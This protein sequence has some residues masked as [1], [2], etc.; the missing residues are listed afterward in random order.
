MASRIMFLLLASLIA[1]HVNS[2]P[3]PPPP[4][5]NQCQC[6][7]IIVSSNGATKT[8]HSHAIGSFKLSSSH[9]NQFKSTVYRN[10]KSLTL[11]GGRKQ[12]WRI[13]GG[14]RAGRIMV[15]NKSCKEL[16]P[17]NCARG[18]KVY[19]KPGYIRDITIK[20]EC[21]NGNNGINPRLDP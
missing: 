8:L 11:I 20:F 13:H 18:W 2:T 4:G 16:C 21:R 15:R 6:G 1:I 7:E 17:G 12:Y 3:P 19:K 10:S 14:S 9:F 5:N